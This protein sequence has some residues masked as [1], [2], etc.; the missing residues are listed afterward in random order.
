LLKLSIH[1]DTMVKI[2]VVHSDF[3]CGASHLMEYLRVP[4]P[5]CSSSRNTTANDDGGV[6]ASDFDLAVTI[7]AM[8][9]HGRANDGTVG[10]SPHEPE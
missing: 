2:A 7:L 4:R 1:E 5:D 3:S 8:T 6:V 10:F 9:G